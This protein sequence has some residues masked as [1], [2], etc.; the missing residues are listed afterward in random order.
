[1]EI[2]LKRNGS[3]V[4]RR[5]ITVVVPPKK[6]IYC[7]LLKTEL[8]IKRCVCSFSV[9]HLHIWNCFQFKTKIDGYKLSH[10]DLTPRSDHENRQFLKGTGELKTTPRYR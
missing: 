5:S 2:R 9:F 10:E 8:K 7:G 1:M 6:I 4:Q 3:S